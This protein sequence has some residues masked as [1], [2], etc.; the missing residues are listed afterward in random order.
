MKDY[1]FQDGDKVQLH[2]GTGA[3]GIVVCAMYSEKGY[4]RT[5]VYVVVGTCKPCDYDPRT[6]RLIEKASYEVIEQ[7]VAVPI[8]KT[9]AEALKVVYD[10]ISGWHSFD[11]VPKIDAMRAVLHK[12]VTAVLYPS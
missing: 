11:G 7:P 5:E 3:H 9:E 12:I 1:Q 4:A 2:N 6:L 10:R 8:T